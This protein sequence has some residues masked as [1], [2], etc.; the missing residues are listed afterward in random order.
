GFDE[1]LVLCGDTP[2]LNS[3]TLTALRDAHAKSG[4][5]LTVVTFE[6]DDPTGYGRMVRNGYGDLSGIVEH[7]DA[8]E[9]ERAIRE[10]NAG[11]Y[12]GDRDLIYDA[13]GQVDAANAQGEIYL[14]D[15]VA[16]LA[17]GGHRVV[18]FLLDDPERVAGIN[19]RQ[20]LAA[21]EARMLQDRL[22][23]LM[24]SGV[25]LEDPT[26]VRIEAPV[27]IGR[28]T[29]LATGVHLLG[30]T[31][32][33]EGCRVDAG[34]V[35]TDCTV[36]DRVHLKPYVVAEDV[37]L[38]DGAT[39]GPFSHL[40]P[41]TELGPGAKVGNFVET[42]KALLGPGAKANHLTYLGDCEVGEGSNIGAGTI[43][44]NYDG[45]YKH[46]TVIGRE[47]FIGSDTQLVAPVTV[48]DRATVGAGTTVTVDVPPGALVVTRADRRIIEGYDERHRQP[49]EARR[50]AEKAAAAKKEP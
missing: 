8:N 31:T 12:L 6:V 20:Q 50:R 7:R 45:A 44:C 15:I 27:T 37:T 41:G 4:A 1:L 35:L 30:R 16:L 47:V 40:R 19:T 36:G 29:T 32:L 39:A 14:T 21:V 13:L 18:S 3:G 9:T 24:A 38:G 42:K 43:T 17:D 28:D 10:V 11:V 33:G 46:Q 48:G 49:R 2:N 26:G 25:T 5:T 22:A 34:C 23:D